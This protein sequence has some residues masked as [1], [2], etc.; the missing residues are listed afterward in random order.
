MDKYP[1]IIVEF[2]DGLQVIPSIWC[3]ADKSSCIWPS[4][5]KT[6]YRINKAILTKEIPREM[7]DWEELP[8]KRIF[9]GASKNF[10]YMNYHLICVIVVYMFLLILMV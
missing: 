5:M 10:I 4:Y 9:G 6:K 7:S 2:H 8:I 3:N 1:F